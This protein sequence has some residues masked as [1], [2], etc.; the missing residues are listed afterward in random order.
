MP[1]KM[2]IYEY[3]NLPPKRVCIEE[4]DHGQNRDKDKEGGEKIVERDMK[5][6]YSVDY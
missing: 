4:D 5:I 1:I 6:F 2:P 3:Q